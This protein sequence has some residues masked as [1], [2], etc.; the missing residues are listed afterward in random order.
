MVNILSQKAIEKITSIERDK[1]GYVVKNS[2][3]KLHV[4]DLDLGMGMMN[5]TLI[6]LVSMLTLIYLT[7]GPEVFDKLTKDI[8]P[9]S[10]RGW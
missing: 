3:I 1:D 8:I 7:A 4:K 9:N 5:L 10:S 2:Y 6:Q